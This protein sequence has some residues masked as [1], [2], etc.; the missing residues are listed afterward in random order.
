MAARWSEKLGFCS[1][2]RR[3]DREREKQTEKQDRLRGTEAE[4]LREQEWESR[5]VGAHT[6]KQTADREKQR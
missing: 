3:E 6:Q 1:L 4:R 5:R 2:E